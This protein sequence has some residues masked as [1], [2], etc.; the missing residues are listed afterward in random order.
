MKKIFKRKSYQ[1]I[2]FAF[3]LNTE[4]TKFF[5]C[6]KILIIF[7][8]LLCSH[9]YEVRS[10]R[11]AGDKSQNEAKKLKYKLKKEIK[12]L[13]FKTGKIFKQNLEVKSNYVV[14]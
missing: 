12:D 11:K 8:I 3:I 9:S 2:I 5:E 6:D 1:V 14:V 7:P 13:F 10:K 4:P